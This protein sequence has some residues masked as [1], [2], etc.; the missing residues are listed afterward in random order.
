[1]NYD[2][3]VLAKNRDALLLAEV[4]AW[5]HMLGKLHEEFL[6]GQHDLD[7]KI[8]D[9]LKINFPSLERLLCDPWP[10]PIWS[11]IPVNEF[12]ANGLSLFDLIK[13]HRNSKAL[14]G[15]QRLMWDAH[16]RGSGIEKSILGRF[17][18]GQVTTVYPATAMGLETGPIDLPALQNRRQ[19]LYEFLQTKLQHL[20][21]TDAH[22]NW[23]EFRK[24]FI[25]RL[26]RDFRSSIAETRRPLNDVTMFDQT[27]A[28]VVFFKAAL[29]QNLMA[30]WKEPVQN[31]VADKYHWRLLR[32][33]LNG[34]AYWGQEGR[35]N[36]L[37]SRKSLVKPALDAVR[38]LLEETYPLGVE[39]YRDENGS[40]FSVPDIE[41]LLDATA[42]S[43]SLRECLRQ[44]IEHTF[45]GEVCPTLELSERTRNLLLLGQLATTELPPPTP[46]PK[47]V[48]EWWDGISRRDVCP[49]CGLRPQADSN[50]KAGQRKVCDVCEGRRADRAK[51]WTRT[52]TTTIWTDEV[53]DINGR[54]ALVVGQ[55]GLTPWLT[56]EAFNSVMVFDPASRTLTDEKRDNKKYLFS[57]TQLLTDIQESLQRR[58]FKN[59][60][61]LSNLVLKNARGGTFEDFYDL[62]VSDTD[63]GEGL[64]TRASAILALAMMRQNP[65]F[66]RIRRVWETTMHFWEKVQRDFGNI[67]L[68]AGPRLKVGG[69]LQAGDR[70]DKPPGTYHT[71][72]LVLPRGV[73]LSVVWDGQCFITC[74]NLVY[75]AKLLG[76]QPPKRE[77]DEQTPDYSQRLQQWGAREVQSLLCGTLVV[78]EPV[79]YGGK[80]KVWGEITVTDAQPLPDAYTPAIPILAEPRTF[81]AL[82]PAD[83]ALEVLKAIKAKYEREMGKVRNRLPLTLGAVYFG[84]RAPLAA[85]LDAG[86]RMLQRGKS[87]NG[88]M[89]TWTVVEKVEIKEKDAAPKYLQQKHFTRWAEV[90]LEREARRVVWRVPLRM[91]DGDTPDVWY[92]YV[93]VKQPAPDRPLAERNGKFQV[94]CPWVLDEQGN[95]QK[96]DL[97]H[98][99]ELQKDDVVYFTPSTFDFEYLD[100]TAR[101]F[102]VS[103]AGGQRRGIGKRQR[104]YLLEELDNI[105]KVWAEVSKISKSQIKM[106]VSLIETKRHDWLTMDTPAA[107]ATATA[108]FRQ[109]VRDVL[110]E[111]KIYSEL[112]ERAAL[113]GMLNDALELHLTI[114]KEG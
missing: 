104:P 42:D 47:R 68:P 91:G 33:G 38:T 96:L 40:L 27:I 53:A 30:G 88:Q 102:E 107:Q 57:Y 75:T 18:S 60:T 95:P 98:A 112:L 70:K 83:R 74:D 106:V 8:P 101:R 15:L 13:E 43:R 69:T 22:V 80:N 61:L 73:K 1:M 63:L 10:G 3:Q 108:T 51:K 23:A 50:T 71:Y 113:S 29:A 99:D 44:V 67:I 11:R 52:L 49:V 6:R 93:F 62:Q 77:K 28:S 82:V 48:R 24:T 65:S 16:G 90:T 7:I 97:V 17:A 58:Q 56:G 14:T 26:E 41:D 34:I 110:H 103:Y 89:G 59:K 105:E 4:A 84:R 45:D 25:R 5:L 81:M 36:D 39:V 9:D 87:A 72:D 100:T 109:F 86:R 92:P 21:D 55:F 31:K 64:S 2:L 79:G 94:P 114:A 54:L 76:K 12:K 19:S 111:A 32:V 37:L 78:E 20:R 46:Q 35:I 85:A 66:A